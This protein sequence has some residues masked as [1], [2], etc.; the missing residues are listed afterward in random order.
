MLQSV[1]HNTIYNLITLLMLYLSLFSFL[2]FPPVMSTCLG[3]FSCPAGLLTRSKDHTLVMLL[4]LLFFIYL[5][6]QGSDPGD[7]SSGCGHVS[8]SFPQFPAV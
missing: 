4:L 6:G 3:S 1:A 8:C 7:L 5:K 2:S